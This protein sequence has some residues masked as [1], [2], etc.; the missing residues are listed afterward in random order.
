MLVQQ[1]SSMTAVGV[2][3]RAFSAASGDSFH[4]RLAY[5]SVH[6]AG[7]QCVSTLADQWTLRYQSTRSSHSFTTRINDWCKL[8]LRLASYRPDGAGA[9]KRCKMNLLNQRSKPQDVLVAPSK[10]SVYPCSL[11]VLPAS[12][13]VC[14]FFFMHFLL[15][16]AFDNRS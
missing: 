5:V 9:W 12:A 4:S 6:D 1:Q 11:F 3:S 13:K 10:P 16:A 15:R 7:R 14:M 8:Q 2:T